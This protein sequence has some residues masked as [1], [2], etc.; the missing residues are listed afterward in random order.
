MPISKFCQKIIFKRKNHSDTIVKNINKSPSKKI[1]Q[2]NNFF[3]K[4][5]HHKIFYEHYKRIRESRALWEVF[6]KILAK[7][8]SPISSNVW[9]VSFKK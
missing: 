2:K 1:E 6:G 4:I 7:I 5:L 3:K 9:I 8:Y